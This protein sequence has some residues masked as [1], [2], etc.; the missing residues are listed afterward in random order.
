[1]GFEVIIIDHHE[2]LNRLPEASIIVDPKQRSDDYPFKQFA[3]AGIT[4]KLAQILLGGKLTGLLKRN[5]L[6][7]VVL[8]TIADMMP[9]VGE[10]KVFIEE[11]LG[12]LKKTLRPGLRI[13]WQINKTGKSEPVKMTTS[14]V[15]SVLNAAGTKNHLTESYLLLTS[16]DQET[17]E[18]FVKTLIK[19]SQE[20]HLRIQEIVQ[21]IEKRL[22]RKMESPIV[23]EG[24]RNWPLALSG[25]VASLICRD[26]QKPVFVFHI[27]KSISRG[28]V[29]TPRNV[30][31]I[32]AM[33][34]CAHLLETFGGHPLASGFTVK[35]ENLDKFRKCLL[36]YFKKNQ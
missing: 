6:E 19:K 7:L 17:A 16:A 18:L 30:N 28:G 8:A 20:K 5:F 11:G 9:Q 23:F 14:R 21:E 27:G 1:M 26:F 2:V 3:N 4:Y 22:L 15:I 33:E 13:F 29:R 36:E 35:N 24:D 10:N 32:K 25:P 31:S 12:A 34:S